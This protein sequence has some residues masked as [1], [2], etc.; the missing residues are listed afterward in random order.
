MKRVIVAAVLVLFLFALVPGTMP[1]HA[2]STPQVLVK[3]QYSVNRY[4]FGVINETVTYKN[5]GTA[6]IPTPSI[7]VGF[8]NVTNKIFSYNVTT[9]GYAVSTSG[10]GNQSLYTIS[11]SGLSVGPGNSTSFSF[12]A[13]VA[14]IA[15]PQKGQNLSVLLVTR[16]SFSVQVK[17]MRLVI[18]MPDSTQFVTNPAGFNKFFSGVNVTYYHTVNNT[19]PSPAL[20]Q[21]SRIQTYSGQDFHPLDVYSASRVIT[22]S[23]SGDPVVQDTLKFKNMGVTQLASLK[24]APLTTPGSTLTVLSTAQPPLLQ[25]ALVSLTGDS[26]SLSN[27]ALGVP[28]DPG[29]N[30]SITYSYPLIKGLYNSTG[31]SVD[32][33]IPR[34]PPIL[35][36]V[37]SYKIS[38]SV[39]PGVRVIQAPTVVLTK[40]SP[41]QTGSVRISYGLS[42]GWALD[43]A[44]PA[45]SMFFVV[46]LV[47]LFVLKTR[48][49]D[50][51]LPEETATEKASEMIRAFEEKTSLINSLFEE[52]PSRDPTALNKA[53]FDELRSRLDTFRSRA[54][55]RLNE[56][57]QT[58][59]TKRFFDL[60]SQMHETERE[61]ERAAKDMLNLYEQ[62]YTKRMR[63]EVFDKLLPS[64]RKRLDRA[65]NQLSD[66]LNTAQREAKLL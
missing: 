11:N 3:S 53:Y 25:Q 40:A 49:P 32:I 63:K 61:V 48:T 15:V 9:P 66:E 56:V 14:N 43:S 39:P 36:F 54:L 65:L 18:K 38:I 58:S 1:S 2:Q 35:A 23:G 64:Y 60:L 19:A 30:Y 26:I 33:Q 37:D 44:V 59:T 16:P 62:F 12:K 13:L 6:A 31:G 29:A 47:G 10:S 52:I 7:Q 55:Q 51:E 22:V 42:V 20:S 4:G 41:L 45:A 50:E 8:G 46:V 34:T 5:N 28:V 17:T 24:V 27:A 21:V 57:K